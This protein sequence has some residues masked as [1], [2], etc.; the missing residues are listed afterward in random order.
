MQSRS[1]SVLLW[2]LALAVTLVS[3]TY[4]RRTGPTYPVSGAVSVDGHRLEF[5]LPRS[6]GVSGDARI[7]ITA[8]DTT[9]RGEITFRRFKSHDEWTTVAMVRD[10]EVLQGTLPHQPPAGK[11]AYQVS[12][13]TGDGAPV[14]LTAQPVIIRFKGSV[15]LIVLIPHV[16]FM[17]MAMLLSTRA[18][19]EAVTRGPRVAGLTWWTLGFLLVGGLI[20]G[21]MVQKHAFGS[22]WTG[23]PFG[24]DMTDNKTLVAFLGWAFAAY[25]VRRPKARYPEVLVAALLLL[26]VYLIPHS[27]WGSELDYTRPP[28]GQHVGP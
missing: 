25:R 22:Y 20:L 11:I 4:Q 8:P 5:A 7:V 15:P 23:W 21:P 19:L 6:H 3:A 13:I 16:I 10:G 12:V 26:A 17:F 24:Q 2:I 14:P 9:L 28:S 27:M 1:K 18:G